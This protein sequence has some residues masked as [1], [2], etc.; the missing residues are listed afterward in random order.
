MYFA[1]GKI[2]KDMICVLCICIMYSSTVKTSIMIIYIF[3]VNLNLKINPAFFSYST[4]DASNKSQYKLTSWPPL[5]SPHSPNACPPPHIT[6]ANT[7]WSINHYS[8]ESGW[9][10]GMGRLQLRLRKGR[11]YNKKWRGCERCSLS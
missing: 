2:Y 5:P 9:G 11:S 10:G 3:F 4:A 7:R 8:A 1:W 6:K